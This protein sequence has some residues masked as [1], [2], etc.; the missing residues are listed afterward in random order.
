MK[1]NRLLVA[2]LL[3]TALTATPGLA[4]TADCGGTAGVADFNGD[5]LTDAVAGDP[6]ADVDGVEGAGTVVVL[7][8]GKSDKAENGLPG[9]GG[10]IE[11]RSPEPAAGEGF[12]WAVRTAH[13]NN[14]E[15]LDVIVG[16]PY[17][18]KSGE[19]AAYVF[20]GT[21]SGAPK[22]LRLEGD[23][24][25]E[26]HFGWSLASADLDG[27]GALVVVGQPHA[28]EPADAGAVHVFELD[29]QVRSAKRLSQ[30]DDGVIGNGE[31]GDLW[32]WS[33]AVGN[34]GGDPGK[35]DLAVGAPFENNDGTGVQVASGKIDSGMVAVIFDVLDDGPYTSAKWDLN[36]ATKEV[37]EKSGNRFGY[38]LAYAETAD[39][40]YLAVSVP[41]A[42]PGG[43]TDAG[44]IVLYERKGAGKLAPAR[45][46]QMGSGALRFPGIPVE[47]GAAIG[48]SMAFVGGAP[49]LAIGEPYA[50]VEGAEQS[51][52]VRFSPVVNQENG[53]TLD[54]SETQ[55]YQ[56][57]GWSMTGYGSPDG[58]APGTGLVIGIPDRKGGGAVAVREA[59]TATL[60][61]STLEGAVDLGY[62][63]G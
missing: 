39:A 8:G 16:A 53:D 54:F 3:L 33:V 43:V 37:P 52:R 14:D 28:D 47:K 34:L 23:N 2:A 22:A 42:D 30:D 40:G 36:Q 18:G 32:G 24:Q 26:G 5:G 60:L 21:P 55:P 4:A 25:A 56:H 29:D 49:V 10:T 44:A 1:L 19:G 35:P 51:G 57:F 59:G 11:L 38:S 31:V 6:S 50:T 7:L 61:P 20:F 13:V 62:A 41:L 45:T 9:L 48:W 46:L 17:A 58:R 63:V 12:G 27:G 15:C